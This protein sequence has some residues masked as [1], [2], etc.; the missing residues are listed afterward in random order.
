MNFACGLRMLMYA[1]HL[2]VL[3]IL[4]ELCIRIFK[5]H[6]PKKL[7]PPF[8]SIRLQIFCKYIKE[9]EELS[10]ELAKSFDCYAPKRAPSEKEINLC[11][12]AEKSNS[13]RSFDVVMRLLID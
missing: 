13:L 11:L 10:N 1:V 8:P 6:L 7:L 5:F 9:T 2:F 12:R 3:C 4:F